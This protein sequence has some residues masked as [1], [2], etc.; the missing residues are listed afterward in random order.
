[1]D[2]SFKIKKKD[3]NTNARLGVISTP[4]GKINTPAFVTVATNAAVKA[5]VSPDDVKKV[6]G[7]VVLGNTYHLMVRD[8]VEAVKKG[9]GLGQFMGWDG[10]TFTD[11][12]GFQVFSL[13]QR[14]EDGVGK[15]TNYDSIADAKDNTNRKR[16][17]TN[18]AQRDEGKQRVR[19]RKKLMVVDDEGVS[20]RS[21]LN[22][23]QMRLTPQNSMQIQMDIGAD[24]IFTFDQPTSPIA[25]I[26][27]SRKAL[28]RTHDWAEQC[29]KE[30][31]KLKKKRKSS[32][33]LFGIVQGGP[34]E[35]LRRESAEFIASLDYF[36]GYGIGGSYHRPHKSA[37]F[38]EL[39]WVIPYL[40][41]NKPRHFLGIGGIE[42][43][44]VAVFQG[45]DTFD[46]VMPTREARHG[47][48]YIWNNMK[49]LEVYFAKQQKQ[50]ASGKQSRK[51]IASNFYK[52]ALV[53]NASFRYN[54]K[55]ID[56]TDPHSPT[57]AYLYHLFRT[58]ELLGQRLATLHNLKFYFTL[59]HR[60]REFL[61]KN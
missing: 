29:I 30:H 19:P 49:S 32:Q 27:D 16:K 1:M 20:F 3:S 46:C 13:G 40:P 41:N 14:L 31:S 5:A 43:M 2:I 60:L 47:R 23:A 61:E 37:K 58:N 15:F 50:I 36:P 9:G 42:D 35:E 56:P 21:H 22:G 25:S 10:P 4:H 7:Q 8:Q 55:P 18:P 24:M 17:D 53:T 12:G 34:H 51:A 59:M 57:Y 38:N 45:C 6:G 28:A 11:S 39:D 33:S 26:E 48:L 54:N 44:I 52:L